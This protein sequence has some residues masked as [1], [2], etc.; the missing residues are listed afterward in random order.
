MRLVLSCIA[1][2]LAACGT[3][4]RSVREQDRTPDAGDRNDATQVE[5]IGRAWDI[6]PGTAAAYRCARVTVPEDIYITEISAQ[7]P[8]GTHH[9][10]LSLAGTKGTSGP[11]GESDCDVGTIGMVALYAS[12][13]GTSPLTLPDGVGIQVHAGQQL[14]LNIHLANTSDEPMSGETAILVRAQRTPPRELAEMVFAGTYSLA[15]P[16][17]GAPINVTGGCI[18]VDDYSLFALWPHMHQLGRHQKLQ[19]I[20]DG[21]VATLH[22]EPFTFAEQSYDLMTPVARVAAGDE[23]RVTCTYVNSTGAT[24]GWGDSANQE[25]CFAG[26]YRYPAANAG[27]FACTD[28]PNQ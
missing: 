7:A 25:M 16:S 3:D 6:A 26:L 9:T 27:A 11:D 5:L 18:A 23:V 1:T 10:V 13:V 22:D 2:A 19:V 12:G 8:A 20:H 21:R 24:V 15:I 17:T 28:N 14:H 4:T